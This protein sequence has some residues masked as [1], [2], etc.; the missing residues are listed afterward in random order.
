MELLIF[1]PKCNICITSPFPGLRNNGAREG[2]KLV[3]ARARGCYHKS[4]L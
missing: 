4:V 2:R 3:R 1:N